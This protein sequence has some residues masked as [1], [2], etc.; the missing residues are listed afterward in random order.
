MLPVIALLAMLAALPTGA[1]ARTRARTAAVA[2]PPGGVTPLA[3][4]PA[5]EL[6][7]EDELGAGGVPTSSLEAALLAKLLSSLSPISQLANVNGLGGAGGVEAAMRRAIEELAGDGELVEE[8]VGVF[9]LAFDFEEQLEEAF[10]ESG[11]E[12]EP[13]GPETLEEAVEEALG[14]SPEEV[15][16]AALRPLSLSK[17]LSDLLAEAAHPEAVAG[18]LFAATNPGELQELLGASLSGEP[19]ALADVA[20]TAEAAGL[21][22]AELAEKL[23][24]TMSELP[25]GARALVAPLSDGR[26]LG[27]FAGRDGLAFALFGPPPAEPEPEPEPEGGE[28]AGTGEGTGEGIGTGPGGPTP[29]QT[30]TPPGSGPAPGPGALPSSGPPATAL[31]QLPPNAAAA[32]PS[33]PQ[34]GTR[35]RVIAHRAKGRA[36]T[37]ALRIPAA[38]LLSVTGSGVRPVRRA[39]A[40]ASARASVQ[41]TITRT[42]VA[43]LRDRG[44]LKLRL[45]I[46]FRPAAGA[47]SS[48]AVTVQLG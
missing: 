7:G 30:E 34:T 1:E 21:S 13:G 22:S 39:F 4:G 19:F 33:T 27:V 46:S 15:I 44:R 25:E 42:S 38:G 28:E 10:E 5:V 41:L 12:N 8:L 17:L 6:L 29:P 36:V 14:S 45:S 37:L 16:D 11:V 40:R 48:A 3:A 20:E 18:A 47:T 35:V 43:A 24:L 9:G 26:A 23:G 32:A 31:T 2:L